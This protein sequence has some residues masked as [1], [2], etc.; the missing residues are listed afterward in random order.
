M[1]AMLSTYDGWT[2]VGQS[3]VDNDRVALP[4]PGFVL[5]LSLSVVAWGLVGSIVWLVLR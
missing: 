5:G 1:M 4:L 2:A 3:L